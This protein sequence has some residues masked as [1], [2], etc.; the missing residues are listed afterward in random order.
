[1]GY[2]VWDVSGNKDRVNRDKIRDKIR[3]GNFAFFQNINWKIFR[4]SQICTG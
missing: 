2:L 3:G 4:V 1:M